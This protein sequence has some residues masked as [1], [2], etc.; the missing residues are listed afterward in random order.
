MKTHRFTGMAFG[1]VTCILWISAASAEHFWKPATV[2]DLAAVQDRLSEVTER[3][4]Q[5]LRQPFVLAYKIALFLATG[6]MDTAT[7][8]REQKVSATFGNGEQPYSTAAVT[9]EFMGYADD[10]LTGERFTLYLAAGREGVWRLTR[11]ERAA[12][13]RGDHR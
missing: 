6:S 8:G 12:Y 3:D 5:W 1:V 13:G 11:A 10:S 7:N 2:V 4:Q 9:V